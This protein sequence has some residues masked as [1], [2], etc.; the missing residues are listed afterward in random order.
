MGVPV[1]I[2]LPTF[3]RMAPVTASLLLRRTAGQAAESHPI[4]WPMAEQRQGA[5]GI[6]DDGDLN[7]YIKPDIEHAGLHGLE[8]AGARATLLSPY[9]EANGEDVFDP[10]AASIWS[11][12][13]ARFAQRTIP[14]IHLIL[15]GARKTVRRA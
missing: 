5:I 4:F 14:A 11:L 15:Y 6:Y 13:Q 10:G 12:A 8:L 1:T 9:E 3:R 2:T 7:V